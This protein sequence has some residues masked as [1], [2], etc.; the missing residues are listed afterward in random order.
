M[1]DGVA[2]YRLLLRAG[3]KARAKIVM[4]TVHATEMFCLPCPEISTDAAR[5]LVA[6][7]RG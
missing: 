3:V 5:E 6:L 2:F 4:G 7:A 1:D